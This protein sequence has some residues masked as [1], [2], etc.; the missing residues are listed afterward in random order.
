MQN[1]KNDPQVRDTQ[2]RKPAPLLKF[3][4]FLTLAFVVVWTVVKSGGN[5]IRSGQAWV[6]IAGMAFLLLLLTIDRLEELRVTP[7]GL[8]AMLA[9]SKARALDEVGAIEDEE[10][11]ADALAGILQARSVQEVRQARDVAIELNADTI[12]QR[13]EEAITTC[14]KIYVR[15]RP[16]A[17]GPME[18][19]MA[20]PLDLEPGQ[21]S[22]SKAKDYLLVFSYKHDSL[23]KLILNKVLGVELSEE[24]F[25][26][27]EMFEKF[28]E[29]PEWNFRRDW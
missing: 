17:N 13:I 12:W 5:D 1:E 22:R 4:V 7:T 14:R 18:T 2:E 25:E 10:A 11:R 26:P 27:A 24:T 21:T 23:I 29:P 15:Y 8:Q 20:A 28:K 9:R 6:I 19:Y 3:L 16:G